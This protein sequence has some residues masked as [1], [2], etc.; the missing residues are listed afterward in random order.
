M[1]TYK[2]I[3]DLIRSILS[4]LLMSTSSKQLMMLI[5]NQHLLFLKSVSRT[6]FKIMMTWRKKLN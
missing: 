5:R 4:I 3:W 2:V 6:L 1:R